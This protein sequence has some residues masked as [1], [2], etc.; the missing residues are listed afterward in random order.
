M[1]FESSVHMVL[2]PSYILPHKGE[3]DASID[4]L[5]WNFVPDIEFEE[6]GLMSKSPS[7]M[8]GG[9]EGGG[10]LSPPYFEIFGAYYAL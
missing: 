6:F 7:T 3:G 10:R 4:S 8:W 1:R 2:P 5:S 9:I